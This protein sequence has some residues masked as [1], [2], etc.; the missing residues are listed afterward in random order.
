MPGLHN[1]KLPSLVST[2]CLSS[3][4]LY[5]RSLSFTLVGLFSNPPFSLCDFFFLFYPLFVVLLLCCVW[6]ILVLPSSHSPPSLS[7][8]MSISPL[9]NC[10]V[11]LV[12]HTAVRLHYCPVIPT[13]LS[14]VHLHTSPLFL[15]LSVSLFICISHLPLPCHPHI[16]P[17]SCIICTNVRLPLLTSPSTSLFLYPLI[18]TLESPILCVAALPS[19]PIPVVSSL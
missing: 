13:S 14:L 5:F 11:A 6:S 10:V 4:I 1:Q 18:P 3:A 15:S 17:L 2:S 7:V 19:L 12:I 8:Q 16:S 9:C